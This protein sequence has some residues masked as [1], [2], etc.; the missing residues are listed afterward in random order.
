M[1]VLTYLSSQSLA[2]IQRAFPPPH[3]VLN[4]STWSDLASD[5]RQRHCDIAIVDPC[6]GGDRL[7]VARLN[8][9]SRDI[10][11]PHSIPLVGYVSVTAAAMRAVQALVRLGASDIVIRGVDDS[12]DAI[13][14]IV[15][16]ALSACAANRVVSAVGTPFDALPSGVAAAIQLAFHRPEQLRSVSDLAVAAQTTRRSLD[17]S[18]ARAGLSSARTLLACA[19]A[20]AAFHLLAEGNLRAAQAASLLGYPSARSL[21]RELYAITGYPA[22]AVPR[23]LSRDAFVV[24]LERR[25]VRRSFDATSSCS[26]Y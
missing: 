21:S 5:L 18:L 23:Q 25:L 1:I 3:H 22:S 6:L 20:N 17:R 9:L 2:Q 4:A 19:R 11:R 16:R 14:A 24:A 10:G 26:S 7:A 8:E 15:H 12:T 13:V